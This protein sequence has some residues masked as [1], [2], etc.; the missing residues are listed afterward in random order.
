MIGRLRYFQLFDMLLFIAKQNDKYSLAEQVKMAI[1]G[2]CQWV[3]LS[4]DNNDE[5]AKSE[6]N[7]I[8]GLC[9]EA[10]IFLTVENNPELARE[11]GMHGVHMTECDNTAAKLREDLGPEAVIGIVCR[12]AAAAKSFVTADIDYA[13]IPSSM[14]QDERR[15]LIADI[16]N[17]DIQL[18]VVYDGDFT[19]EEMIELLASDNVNGFAT[20]K[21]IIGADEPV[22]YLSEILSKFNNRE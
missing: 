8:V 13:I 4:I 15:Q 2:G 17:A 11:Y 16:R 20:G 3:I 9:K 19:A 18:P 12:S 10:A 5:V 1:E 6:L 22:A 7:D 21:H 14:P